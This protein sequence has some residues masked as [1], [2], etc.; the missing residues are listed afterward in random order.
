MMESILMIAQLEDFQSIGEI[1]NWDVIVNQLG[2][3][4]NLGVGLPL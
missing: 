4:P 3:I 2:R 1:S